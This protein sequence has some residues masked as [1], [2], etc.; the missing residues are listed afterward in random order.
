MS[1]WLDGLRERVTWRRRKAGEANP[2]SFPVLDA[3]PPSSA[4]NAR[5]P[6]PLELKVH[7]CY[8]PTHGDPFHSR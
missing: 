2:L 4:G 7:E 6:G 1:G 3:A 5:K 8:L